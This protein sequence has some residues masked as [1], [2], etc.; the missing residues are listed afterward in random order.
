MPW[1]A[2]WSDV[3][4]KKICRFLLQRYLGRF[5]EEKLTLDQLNVDFYNGTG[6]VHNVT[7]YCQQ[8][9]R[10]GGDHRSTQYDSEAFEARAV[11]GSKS[12]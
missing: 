3:I 6:T 5:L 7:L 4:K 11:S 8:T 2:P 10:L 12:Y 9:V 1:Y